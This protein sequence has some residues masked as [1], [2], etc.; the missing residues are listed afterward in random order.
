MKRPY[1][2]RKEASSL[3]ASTRCANQTQLFTVYAFCMVPLYGLMLLWCDKHPALADL[4]HPAL[5]GLLAG[6]GWRPA[7]SRALDLPLKPT[8]PGEAP[9]D[10][11]G[12][13]RQQGVARPSRPPSAP[14]QEVEF[15]RLIQRTTTTPPLGFGALGGD[16]WKARVDGAAAAG[17]RLPLR[18]PLPPAMRG[19]TSVEGGV[20][21]HV[22]SDE[23]SN[24]DDEDEDE[25]AVL[26]A[27][28][29]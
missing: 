19:G 8:P 28:L 1:D 25:W 2:R 4:L 17:S 10:S 20:E 14:E 23:G 18:P 12:H 22:A 21:Q 6:A 11:S 13:W 9:P 26:E 15:V 5:A 24:E 29:V 27:E 16:W 7:D 3:G